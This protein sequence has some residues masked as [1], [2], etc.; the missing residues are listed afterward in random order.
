M[1][2][3][4]IN[5]VSDPDLLD[6]ARRLLRVKTY[7]AT[8]NLALAEVVRL[9]KVQSLPLFFGQG[10]WQG[11]LAEMREDFVSRSPRQKRSRPRGRP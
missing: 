2:M 6:Q 7:S 1:R 10:L 9:R 5:L 8:V 11:D 4:R 3:K